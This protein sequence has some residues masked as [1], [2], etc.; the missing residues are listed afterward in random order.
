MRK[1]LSVALLFF[2][3]L[4]SQTDKLFVVRENGIAIVGGMGINLVNA[5]EIVDYINV[6]ALSS[7]RVDDFATAVDFFGG[8]ELPIGEAWGLKIEHTYLFKSYSFLTA[9]G[10]TNELFYSVQAPSIIL[11]K[12]Y[13]GEGYFVK[14][15]GG[16]GYHFGSASEK[17]ST[18]GVTSDYTTSGIGMKIDIVGQTAFDRNFYGYIGGHMGWELLGKFSTT[19]SAP[20]ALEAKRMK[21]FYAGLRFG[22]TY[23]W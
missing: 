16:G 14:M 4:L 23:Y 13:S 11:Q 10:A 22:I 19:N 21:Y 6:T 20:S 17:I 15:G 1:V 2:S 3:P 8:I 5:P 12:V 9:T 7:Q 18:F